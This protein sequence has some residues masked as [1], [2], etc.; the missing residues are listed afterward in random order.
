V[1]FMN[2]ENGLRGGRGYFDAHK[3][4]KHIAAIES[5][6]GVAP[7]M[8]FRTTLKGDKLAALEGRTQALKA[9]G[10]LTFESTPETG[11]DTSPL[12]EAGVAGFAIVPDSIKYFDYHHS[13][14]DTLDKVDPKDL[15]S[16]TAALAALTWILADT[17]V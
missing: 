16:D 13:P 7:P 15:A 4:E 11:A 6:S 14:A 2:E 8:G 9:L 17:G 5:D 10:N 3:N 12:T 1:L